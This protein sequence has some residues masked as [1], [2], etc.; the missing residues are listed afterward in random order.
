MAIAV[1]AISAQN[2]AVCEEIETLV[3]GAGPAS[4]SLYSTDS[5]LG[6]ALPFVSTS[7]NAISYSSIIPRPLEV[8]QEP[9]RRPKASYSTTA[10]TSSFHTIPTLTTCWTRRYRM[11][12]TGLRTSESAMYAWETTG[13]TVSLRCDWLITDP[14][15]NNIAQLPVDEQ[16]ACLDGLI[17][18]AETRAATP[19][20]KPVSF[21]KWIVRNMG[22]GLADVFM[23]P[24]NFKVWGVPPSQVRS[25]LVSADHRC[26]ANG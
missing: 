24:Y 14:L 4:F 3:I 16:V 8:W 18:A 26:N 13:C 22:E 7:C 5:R 21:D 15:Q 10:V 25:M 17:V 6:W 23:R 2:E 19:N 11:G 9:T 1:P 12:T 20:V